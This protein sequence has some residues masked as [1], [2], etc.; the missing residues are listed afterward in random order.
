V[1]KRYDIATVVALMLVACVTT[2]VFTYLF[3]TADLRDQFAE[4]GELRNEFQQFISVR[5]EIRDN[6]IGEQ[7]D[8]GLI[9]GAIGGMVDALGDPWSRFLTP[10]E[11]SAYF[12]QGEL[13]L[14]LGLEIRFDI[15]GRGALV[16]RVH[17]NSPASEA[18]IRPLDVIVAVDG[19][20]FAE[21]DGFYDAVE[22]LR[23][24]EGEVVELSLLREGEDEREATLTRSTVI[25]SP[26]T[27]TIY[28][29]E[30]VGYIRIHSFNHGAFTDFQNAVD[31]MLRANV[32]G[33][34]FDVRNNGGGMLEVMTEML[35]LL[36]PGQR[37]IYIRDRDGELQSLPETLDEDTEPFAGGLPF[38]VLTNG[39]SLSAAEFFAA[40]LQEHHRATVIGEHTMG[41]SLAQQQFEFGDG[42]A[43]I[44]SVSEYL[45][46]IGQVSLA[47]TGG[48]QPD[49][50]IAM[51]ARRA[52]M[53]PNVALEDDTQ[54]L[55]ALARMGELMGEPGGE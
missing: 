51:D 53:L 29:E 16:T 48:V 40:A 32:G 31:R 30:N 3:V 25:L 49:N 26:V 35:E 7:D 1:K 43:L 20:G 38:I 6:Y 21:M 27:S 24:D 36:L 17:N 9:D 41:K 47:E 23:G 44:L 19:V 34:V 10:A 54:L 12:N 2:F 22:R 50:V 55:A 52:A 39:Q 46:P 5:D 42:S 37:V 4:A 14:Q 33:I 28:T 18:D 11:F 45:T 15:E 13:A 8:E